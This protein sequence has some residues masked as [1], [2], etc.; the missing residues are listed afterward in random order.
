VERPDRLFRDPYV[1]ALAGPI[2]RAALAASEG[3]SG[4]ENEFLPI[5]TRFFDDCL[6]A[7]AERL[8]QVV[9]L[10]AGLDTRAF[11]I[12]L[13][14]HLRWFEID[15]AEIF[16][17]KE[18]VLPELGAE[19]SCQRSV[20]VADL[21]GAWSRSLLDAGFRAG[22]EPHGSPRACSSTSPR[23]QELPASV[24]RPTTTWRRWPGVAGTA[25]HA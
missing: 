2:G 10:G 15:R 14:A 6:S 24:A 3:V 11:R 7:D 19:T 9:L 17:Q 5:R 21:S 13:P 12:A 16:E 4:A 23:G 22:S 25:M 1:A 20:V 18:A 8:D